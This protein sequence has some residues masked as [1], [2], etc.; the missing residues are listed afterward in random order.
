M[1]DY[2]LWKLWWYATLYGAE[3]ET[4]MAALDRARGSS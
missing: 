2:Q 3:P 1:T 4:R